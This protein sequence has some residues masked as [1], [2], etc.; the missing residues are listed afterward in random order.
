MIKEKKVY[1]S[2][3]SYTTESYEEFIALLGKIGFD[4]TK[5]NLKEMNQRIMNTHYF[6]AYC[7]EMDCSNKKVRH[8]GLTHTDNVSNFVSYYFNPKTK[9]YGSAIL[10]NVMTFTEASKNWGLGE[11]TLRSAI[12]TDRFEENIDYKKSGNVWLITYD[13]MVRV[14]GEPKC[15]VKYE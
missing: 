1:Y 15:E 12:K 10:K 3:K 6:N 9:S 7:V 13:A 11:S 2:G 4:I 5:L 8:I 14:Y